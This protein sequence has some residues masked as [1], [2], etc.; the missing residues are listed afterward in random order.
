MINSWETQKEEKKQ[1]W[2]A[3]LEI[4]PRA[5]VGDCLHVFELFLVFN[6]NEAN[7][8]IDSSSVYL[9]HVKPE[10]VLLLHVLE[11]CVIVSRAE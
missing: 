11:S 9:S 8:G 6:V 5:M 1:V 10:R 2:P 4:V 3:T 7:P